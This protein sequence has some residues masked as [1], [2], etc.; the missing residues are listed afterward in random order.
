MAGP[1]DKFVKSVSGAI[2][3][4]TLDVKKF[5][6][7]VI[8]VVATWVVQNV[9]L[10]PATWLFGGLEW[11]YA[12]IYASIDGAIRSALG[13]AGAGIWDAFLGPNGAITTLQDVAVGLAT[14]AGIG[15]PLA[16]GLVNLALFGIVV[17]LIYL[18]ARAAAG[19]LTGGVLS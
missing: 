16:A 18:L 14:S 3:G 10:E 11:I 6:N 17:G 13:S 7:A 2:D 5:Q 12:S 4:F 8:M 9:F 15:A 19:Y 1:I